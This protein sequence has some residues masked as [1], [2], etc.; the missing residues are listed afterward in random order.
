MHYHDG[1]YTTDSFK[2]P[3]E[4]T[5]KTIL[6]WLVSP[7]DTS[8]VAASLT[9]VQGTLLEKF[10]TTSPDEFSVLLKSTPLSEDHIASLQQEREAYRY[11]KSDQFVMRSQLDCYDPRLPGTGVFDIK[12]RAC[13]PT[14]LDVLNYQ[15]HT[16]YTIKTLQG[17]LESFEKEYYDLIRSAF[18]K[19]RWETPFNSE[20]GG[21]HLDIFLQFPSAH[22]EYGWCY[23]CL[24][25]HGATLRFPVYSCH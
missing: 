12:T 17:E 23:R 16:G 7:Q 11:A 1:V 18:L 21:T 3:A 20:Q 24:P 5:E 4:K 10:L 22:W 13:V 19:Y 25:Q 15:E 8:S 6:T 14:R 2:T 9:P